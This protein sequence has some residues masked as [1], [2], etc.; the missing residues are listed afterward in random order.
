M[1]HKVKTKSSKD[2]DVFWYLE[3]VLMKKDLDNDEWYRGRTNGMILSLANSLE[4]DVVGFITSGEGVSKAIAQRAFKS[5]IR[6][7]EME[8][9]KN[10]KD[11]PIN[12]EEQG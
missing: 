5:F 3:E 1:V 12:V 6:D 8:L 10:P 9:K 4:S 7:T 2:I 11:R